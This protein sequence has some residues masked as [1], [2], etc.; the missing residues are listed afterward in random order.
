MSNGPPMVFPRAKGSR[1][2][3]AQGEISTDRAVSNAGNLQ[4]S[5]RSR[6]RVGIRTSCAPGCRDFTHGSR[7]ASDIRSSLAG[8]GPERR[9]AIA[10]EEGGN[11]S[12]GVRQRR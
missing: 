2:H 7:V 3:L 6:L 4:A 8:V 9:P 5:H 11:A 10:Q 1:P 12:P